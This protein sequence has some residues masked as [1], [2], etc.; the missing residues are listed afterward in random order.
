MTLIII[1]HL[2]L[3]LDCI[4]IFKIRKFQNTYSA[5]IGRTHIAILYFRIWM[6]GIY[7]LIIVLSIIYLTAIHNMFNLVKYE[8]NVN[9]LHEIKLKLG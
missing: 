5:Y 8:E 6:T 3:L 4:L 7:D 9:P 1:I 2:I